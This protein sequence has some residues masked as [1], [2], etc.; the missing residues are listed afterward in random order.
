M[1]VIT[2]VLVLVI[3]ANALLVIVVLHQRTMNAQYKQQ[4]TQILVTL[5]QARRVLK[6]GRNAREPEQPD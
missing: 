5:N 6:D 1:D 4:I 2:A 3:A